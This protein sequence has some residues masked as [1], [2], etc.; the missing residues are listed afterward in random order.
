VLGDAWLLEKVRTNEIPILEVEAVQLVASHLGIHYVFI[1]NECCAF[2][3]VGDSL[4]D[5]AVQ[6]VSRWPLQADGKWC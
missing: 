1:D 2:R 5:L 3:V 6:R 4:A